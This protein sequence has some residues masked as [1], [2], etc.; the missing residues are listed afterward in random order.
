MMVLTI[1]LILYI[2][3]G[4]IMD[5]MSMILLT[6]PIFFP[7]VTSMDFGLPPEE[8]AIWFGILV[9]MV[10]EIGLITPPV[11]LNLFIINALAKDV[12]TRETYAGVLPFVTA[13]LLRIVILTLFPAI[14][15]LLVR[16]VY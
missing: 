1:I 8:L 10:A 14:S 9:L 15:L 3:F 6:V 4:C 7:I 5:S 12:S 11:G 16:L 13:D 2:I